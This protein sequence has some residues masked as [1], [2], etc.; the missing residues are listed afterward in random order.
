M[1][2]TSP[3]QYRMQEQS[4]EEDLSSFS[5]YSQP[6]DVRETRGTKKSIAS[7]MY[8]RC[9][10]ATTPKNKLPHGLTVS[11]LK[12]MTRARLAAEA[13][14]EKHKQQTLLVVNQEQPLHHDNT[15]YPI[16]CHSPGD[17]NLV[18][19]S[20]SSD[21]PLLQFRSQSCDDNLCNKFL[22]PNRASPELSTTPQSQHCR[23]SPLCWQR[24]NHHSNRPHKLTPSQAILHPSSQNLPY[25]P[26]K[27]SNSLH[28]YQ[29][30]RQC[31]HPS[32]QEQHRQQVLDS[33][34]TTSVAS[35][36]S[37]LGSESIHSTPF[38][39]AGLQPPS[40]DEGS[41]FGRSWSYPAGV[42]L[43]SAV[44]NETP[45]STSSSF[46]ENSS[47][48]SNMGVGRRSRLGSSPPGFHLEV[49]HEDRPLNVTVDLTLPLFET[50]RSN[51]WRLSHG[52]DGC[53][54]SSLET[55]TPLSSRHQNMRCAT[56]CFEPSGNRNINFSPSPAKHDRVVGSELILPPLSS[57]EKRGARSS[58]G[59][60]S[61]DIPNLVAESVLFPSHQNDSR[62]ALGANGDLMP[63]E[64]NGSI[65]SHGGAVS[66]SEGALYNWLN[67]ASG[68]FRNTYINSTSSDTAVSDREE[69][70]GNNER[71][72][73]NNSSSWARDLIGLTNHFGSILSFSKGCSENIDLSEGIVEN[74]QQ[75]GNFVSR[76]D[77][78]VVRTS[79]DTSSSV[80]S[81][82]RSVQDLGSN[83]SR[84]AQAQA[85][86]PIPK[87]FPNEACCRE[88]REEV[89][90]PA[91][92]VS[93][94]TRHRNS[95]SSGRKKRDS[96]RR[97][98]DHGSRA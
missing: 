25:N 65:L 30:Y 24:S 26:M 40:N 77:P 39:G 1:R 32:Q 58:G 72:A 97:R 35:F 55:S 61:G 43:G 22:Q 47:G 82:P 28:S 6:R 36:N 93:S 53:I 42:S 15:A 88:G 83:I 80:F 20:S 41:F 31:N 90:S 37:T 54:P 70:A 10:V 56:G 67:T 2:V 79:E 12:E 95:F 73:C 94:K 69:I 13:A 9:P 98:R 45:K 74:D 89:S 91:L 49:A 60:F 44:E 23:H 59:S 16:V 78:E 75:P 5:G 19:E 33:L 8:Q 3:N 92:S 84:Q 76:I 64:C 48:L 7:S 50:P 85:P 62:S 4:Q 29:K 68:V 38:L 46:F 52:E 34:E 86:L 27:H 17:F 21:A 57:D 96:S 66:V 51:K 18:S 87:L 81:E 11:E 63:T 71:K 14:S